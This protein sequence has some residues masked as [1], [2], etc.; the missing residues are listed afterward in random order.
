MH[1][2]FGLLAAGVSF[3]AY[4]PLLHDT[5]Q[6]TATPR[7]FSWVIWSSLMVTVTLTTEGPARGLPFSYAIADTVFVIV[8]LLTRT[9][10]RNWTWVET[11]CGILATVALALYVFVRGSGDLALGLCIFAD[12]MGAAPTLRGVSKKPTSESRWAWTLFFLGGLLNFGAA[13]SATFAALGYSIY[14]SAVTGYISGRIWTDRLGWF[15]KRH[16][17]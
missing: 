13:E 17:S 10:E 9:G 14:I 2:V 3:L 4:L 11:T 8:M 16:L 7:L 6:R 5:L 12:G 15:G 1:T